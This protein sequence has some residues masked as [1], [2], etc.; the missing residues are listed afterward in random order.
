MEL[1]SPAPPFTQSQISVTSFA[2]NG[3]SGKTIQKSEP[4]RWMLACPSDERSKRPS[5]EVTSVPRSTPPKPKSMAGMVVWSAGGPVGYRSEMDAGVPVGRALETAIGRS[6]QRAEIDSA[7]AKID[8]GN[9]RVVRRRP[10]RIP[11]MRQFCARAPFEKFANVL[12]Q[13]LATPVLSSDLASFTV[14]GAST[15]KLA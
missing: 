7:Q 14:L 15:V 8:G 12:W 10:S 3:S 11:Q 6:H 2:S 1:V 13:P 9:G 4:L 5:G